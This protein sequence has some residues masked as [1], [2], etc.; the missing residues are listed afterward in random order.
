M[1]TLFGRSR[2]I[3]ELRSRK[4][5]TRSLGERLAV[6]TVIQGTAA[7]IIKVAMVAPRPRC[8]RRGSRRGWCS[9]ST[10]SCCSRRPR[11]RSSGPCEIVREEME[12]A[13][14]LDPPLE[15]DVGVGRELAGGEVVD[16]GVAVVL[17][18]FAGGLVALQA[19]IN[20]GLGQDDRQPARRRRSRSRSGWWRW[21]RSR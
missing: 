4:Y 5:Q 20:A 19:P 2:Q 15:V 7:D 12:G 17:T 21:W 11:T 9:R 18:A 1:T 10:T 13:F 16:K 8:A 14:E 3:P 6:N